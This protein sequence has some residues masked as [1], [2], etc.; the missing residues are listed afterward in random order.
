[1]QEVQY[2]KIWDLDNTKGH[3]QEIQLKKFL[4]FYLQ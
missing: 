4:V 2:L 3:K 1:M